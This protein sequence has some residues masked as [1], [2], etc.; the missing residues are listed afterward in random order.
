VT[1]N[2]RD[3]GNLLHTQTARDAFATG[4]ADRTKDSF[5]GGG[6][7]KAGFGFGGGGGGGCSLV[8]AQSASP[9]FGLAYLLVLLMPVAL[10]ALRRYVGRR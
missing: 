8:A 5:M 3:S 6:N 10:V 7:D 4:P 9:A 1:N 2:S